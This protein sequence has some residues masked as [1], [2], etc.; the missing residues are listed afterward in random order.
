M[1]V[2]YGINPNAHYWKKFMEDYNRGDNPVQNTD[3]HLWQEMPD[4]FYSPSL[5]VTENGGI[6]MNVGG[7]VFVM[8]IREWH[9]LA[10]LHFMVLGEI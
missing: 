8:P 10:E 2:V 1:T 5:H 4:D 7:C 6:G 9:R 3:R